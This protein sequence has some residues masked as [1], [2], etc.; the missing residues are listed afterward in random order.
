MPEVITLASWLQPSEIYEYPTVE[1]IPIF[2]DTLVLAQVPAIE[3][4]GITLAEL[5][6]ADH[7]R[8]VMMRLKLAVP[9]ANELNFKDNLV[10]LCLNAEAQQCHYRAYQTLMVGRVRPG[11][12]H[13]FKLTKRYFY[14]DDFQIC[15]YDQKAR[16]LA[17]T[18]IRLR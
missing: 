3:P 15:L 14:K 6:N 4:A 11:A 10:L 16:P 17:V 18:K 9:N 2:V 13:L 1:Y 12:C 5:K 7:C 8:D